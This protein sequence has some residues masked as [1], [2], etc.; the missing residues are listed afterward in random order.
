MLNTPVDVAFYKPRGVTPPAGQPD[1]IVSVGLTYRDYPTLL[2]ALHSLPHIRCHLYIGSAWVESEAGFRR[3]SVPENVRIMPYVHPRVL[4][5]QCLDSRFMA[6]PIRQTTELTAGCTSAQI[7]QAV[8]RAVI[9]TDI[10][11]LR[12]YIEDRKTGL[13]VERA[14]P[15]AMA[16]AI[17]YLWDHPEEAEAMGSCGREAMETKFSL[18]AWAEG[19]SRILYTA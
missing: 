8:G 3:E 12:D 10:P 7:A 6:I 19:I 14:N 13:L 15:A 18:D 11:G 16:A 5:E 4:R 1:H 9:A 2:S 17:S